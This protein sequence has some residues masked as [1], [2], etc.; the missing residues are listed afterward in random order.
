[1]TKRR[2][3]LAFATL[4]AS[5][6]AALTPAHAAVG[7]A[8]MPSSFALAANGLPAACEPAVRPAIGELAQAEPAGLSKSQ[9]ILGGQVSKLELM[10]LQQQAAPGEALA[11]APAALPGAALAPSAGG[12]DCQRLVLPTS[13]I[14]GFEPGLRTLAPASPDDF[15]AS[16]R[17]E[18]SKTAFDGAWNRVRRGGVSRRLASAL[19]SQIPGPASTATLAAVNSWT[20][21][22]V[23]YVEDAAGYGRPDFW[24][25]ANTTLRRGQGD[26][27]DIA[28][29]K[30]QLLAALGVSSSDMYLTIA[31]D[32]VRN[33]DHAVLIVK[34][35]GRSWMLDNATNTVLDAS[36]SY[37]YRPILSFSG[38]SKWVHG[39]QTAV[40][41]AP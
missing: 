30:M 17:L 21:T 36:Q 10:R 12:G 32:L 15:L 29:A 19:V 4:A 2:I 6:M 41:I 27:E 7:L 9:A 11:A 37:D 25:D 8:F 13:P 24:A 40:A 3:F 16:K 20:N 14:Q 18:V 23:R 35:E 31:R 34:L 38:S 39:Y 28:V 1:M 22:R 5:H 26:C 33:A